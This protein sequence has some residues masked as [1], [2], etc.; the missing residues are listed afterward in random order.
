MAALIYGAALRAL[1][2]SVRTFVH[3]L[4]PPKI[5]RALEAAAAASV[6]STLIAAEFAAVSATSFASRS[7][8]GAGEVSVRANASTGE[9][10][11]RYE[12]DESFLELSVKLPST[13]PLTQAELRFTQ[14]LG[15][16]ELQTRTWILGMSGILT[17]QNGAVAQGL[18]QWQ[19]N[20][21]A[22]FVGVEPCPICYA[23]IH[24]VDR[25][26]PSM[27]CRQ[28]D[29]AFHGTCLY[30]WFR[31]GSRSIC[32]LCQQQWGTSLRD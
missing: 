15:F 2:A 19:R 20:I 1:P 7:G 17:H 4:K 32:P 30:T 28:C 6:S 22:E 27:R 31:T 26:K 14:R 5:A 3:D 24:P 23:V 10:L 11:A 29:N 25:R 13:Y 21:A 16:S 9:I 12:I 8:A 18:L